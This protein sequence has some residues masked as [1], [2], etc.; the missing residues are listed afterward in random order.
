[1]ASEGRSAWFRQRS[2]VTP[3]PSGGCPVTVDK[4]A[5]SERLRRR[6]SVVEESALCADQPVAPV[7]VREHD[8]RLVAARQTARSV[9]EMKFARELAHDDPA[10]TK[11]GRGRHSMRRAQQPESV[12]KLHRMAPAMTHAT[13]TS[14]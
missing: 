2:R 9:E 13:D 5:A 12:P 11:V 3:R 8:D 6:P 7:S 14:T 10:I 1:M 4:A